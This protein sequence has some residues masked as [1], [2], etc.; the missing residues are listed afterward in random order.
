MK[1]PPP[2]RNSPDMK[3]LKRVLKTMLEMLTR[4]SLQMM[5]S[6][7]GLGKDLGFS[8]GLAIG[9]L[10]MLQRVC[11]QHK[12]DL[13]FCGGFLGKGR[14]KVGSMDLEGMGSELDQDA[15]Y[16]IAQ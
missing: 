8:K 13:L 1:T 4:S 12:L 10:A 6:G 5:V 9:S 7:G 11:G 14:S 16:E 3:L 2:K 15:L